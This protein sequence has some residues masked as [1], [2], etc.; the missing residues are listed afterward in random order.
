[1]AELFGKKK[2]NGFDDIVSW[3]YQLLVVFIFLFFFGMSIKLSQIMTI[4]FGF[5]NVIH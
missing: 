1:V 4:S 5:V 3:K 2:K